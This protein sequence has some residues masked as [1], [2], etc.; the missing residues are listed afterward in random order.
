[1]LI[2]SNI[3]NNE[4]VIISSWLEPNNGLKNLPIIKSK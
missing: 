1:M 4:P 2:F 3:L